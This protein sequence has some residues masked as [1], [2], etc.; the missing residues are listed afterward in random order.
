[1]TT[2]R[3]E[4]VEALFEQAL[5]RPT[6]DR[7]AW[8]ALACGSDDAL[9]SEVRELL[10]AHA[11][12]DGIL[13]RAPVPPP[14]PERRIGAYRLVRELGRGGMG[15]VYLAERDDGQFTRRVALK[16]LRASPDAEELHRRFIAERQILA[17]LVHP[18]IAQLLDG[19]V[20]DGRLPYLVMEYVD[21]LPITTYCDRQRLTIDDRLRLFQ[22]VC[23]AVHHAHQNLV[24]HRDLKPSNI[25]VTGD[26]QVKLLDFGIAKLLNPGMSAVAVPVTR[27]ELRIMTPEY[28]SPEQVRGDPLSTASDVY[29]LGVVLYELLAGRRPY[30]LTSSAPAELARVICEEDPDPPSV[31]ILRQRDDAPPISDVSATR[32]TTPE[33]LRGE[34]R[35]DLDAIVLM[36]MRKEPGRRFASAALLAQDLDRALIAMPVLAHRDTRSYRARKFLRR[37]RVVV[38][39]G[40]LAA[41]SLIGGAGAALWQARVAAAQRDIAHR[42]AERAE[43][44]RR[45]SEEVANFLFALFEASEPNQA[46][47]DTLQA[48]DLLE[49]GRARIAGLA[50]QPLVQARM[51][52]VM[53]RVYT[54]LGEYERSRELLEQALGLRRSAYGDRHLEVARTRAELG[55]AYRRLGRYV[56]ATREVTAA[57]TV[58]RS[59]LGGDHA[60][61]APTLMQLAGLRVYAADLDSS[62]RLAQEAVGVLER[63]FGP[64]DTLVAQGLIVQAASLR[65]LADYDEAERLVRRAMQIYEQT[66]GTHHPLYADAIMNLGYLLE[67]DGARLDETEAIYR[68]ALEIRRA[69]LGSRHRVVAVTLGN[70]AGVISRQGRGTEADSLYREHVALLGAVLGAG[71]PSLAEAQSNRAMALARNGR[72]AEAEQLA[73]ESL[74]E[75]R[76]TLGPTHSAV[77]WQLANLAHVLVANGKLDEAERTMRNAL[78]VRR[79]AM[80]DSG[81]SPLIGVLTAEVGAILT[82]KGEYAVAESL[83][84]SGYAMMLRTVSARH[85]D[86]RRVREFLADLYTRS[87]RPAEA[88]LYQP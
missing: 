18:N 45:Q 40:A 14:A 72:A 51:M 68:R 28:A 84:V 64:V 87:G 83:L 70:L 12:P 56:E 26:G 62:A 54:S 33:R 66:I 86:A 36:A 78:E 17:S 59:L 52:D 50:G 75:F 49:R 65:R 41:L 82:K 58:Q 15:V 76:R 38:S 44:E 35:G 57:L 42:Q 25:M 77:G 16:L 19:G 9:Q 31:A 29:A 24:I 73:R 22:D 53:A 79:N 55:E 85:Y 6:R 47:S 5:T 61:L 27:T 13:D 32:H 69:A 11:M 48:R 81:D 37:H 4:R 88:A 39:A 23:K 43:G 1:M 2:G 10:Q 21:G 67:E 63:A 30:R 80:S 20:T 7:E 8:L 71:H 34:L 74:E 60:E 3:S 46:E